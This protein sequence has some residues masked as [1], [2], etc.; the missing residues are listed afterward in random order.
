MVEEDGINWGVKILDQFEW[1]STNV[2]QTQLIECE[3]ELEE[4]Y[5]RCRIRQGEK[6]SVGCE[7]G[8]VNSECATMWAH[9]G[10]NC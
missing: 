4:G 10:S 7:M 1:L 2:G 5:C 3:D 9:C 6:C 8:K